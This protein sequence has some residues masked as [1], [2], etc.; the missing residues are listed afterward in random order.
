MK[1]S[2]RAIVSVVSFLSGIAVLVPLASYA[3][4]KS[5]DSSRD[6][7]VSSTVE[8]PPVT[9]VGELRGSNVIDLEPIT[10]VGSV[11]KMPR[12]AR[13]SPARRVIA[14]DQGG[15]PGAR[16]VVAIGL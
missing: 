3:G 10:I 8:I 13:T 5:A 7:I 2:I 11:R 4:Q 9:I 12:A 14:L 6:P 16:S 1:N 15:R